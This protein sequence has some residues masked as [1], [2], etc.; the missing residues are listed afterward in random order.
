[1]CGLLR[2]YVKVC[3]R[4][5]DILLFDFVVCEFFVKIGGEGFRLKLCG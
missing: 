2:P 4:E 1:M 3:L 5:I